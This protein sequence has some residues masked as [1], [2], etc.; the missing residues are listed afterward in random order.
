MIATT[1]DLI[2]LGQ[3][4]RHILAPRPPHISTVLRWVLHGVGTPAIRLATVKVGGRR[5]TT[6]RAIDDFVAATTGQSGMDLTCAADQRDIA[7]RQ[8]EHALDRD[9]LV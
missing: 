2:P 1:E 8:A 4:P 6:Q 7:R 5:Y 9:G 3:V